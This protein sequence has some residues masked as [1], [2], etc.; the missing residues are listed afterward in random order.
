M[1]LG[2]ARALE[3]VYDSHSST[4]IIRQ[5]EIGDRFLTCPSAFVHPFSRSERAFSELP[6]STMNSASKASEVLTSAYLDEDTMNLAMKRN[7]LHGINVCT[8]FD[9]FMDLLDFFRAHKL[10]FSGF[11]LRCMRSLFQNDGT[12]HQKDWVSD[13]LEE[14]Q[15]STFMR[16]IDRHLLKHRPEHFCHICEE[17]IEGENPNGSAISAYALTLL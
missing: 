15:R 12:D 14:I 9:S 1:S 7:L 6:K 13:Y 17:G 16:E 3:L 11:E 4:E 2:K 8:Y 5:D 10:H